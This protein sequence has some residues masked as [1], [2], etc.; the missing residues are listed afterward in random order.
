MCGLGSKCG[1]PGWN[2]LCGLSGNWGPEAN[3]IIHV[4]A[5]VG[6]LGEMGFV[7]FL[8]N[9]GLKQITLYM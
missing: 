2:G 5:S 4:K 9:G 3:N 1:L 6:S 8:A 7:G